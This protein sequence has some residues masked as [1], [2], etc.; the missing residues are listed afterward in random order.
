MG[1]CMVLK[2]TRQNNLSVEFGQKKRVVETTL[3]RLGTPRSRYFKLH[4]Q[5]N[6]HICATKIVHRF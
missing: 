5:L 1:K 2:F 6:S 3:F 4:T